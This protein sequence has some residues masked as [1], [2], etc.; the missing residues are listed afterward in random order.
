M[1][2]YDNAMAKFV[3]KIKFY[4]GIGRSQVGWFTGWLPELASVLA[5]IW[6][7]TGYKMSTNTALIVFPIFISFLAFLGYIWYKLGLFTI[8]VM[9]NA[10]KDPV[11]SE[12]LRAA[13]KIN[14]GDK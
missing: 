7:F 1:K 11:Q 2:L 9:T 8:E 13:R 4:V 12:L 6:Y 14:E 5:L 10:N 3:Y